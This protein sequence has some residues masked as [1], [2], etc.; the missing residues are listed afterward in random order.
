MDIGS[1]TYSRL[2]WLVCRILNHNTDKAT[3]LRPH[4]RRIVPSWEIPLQG[5]VGH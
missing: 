4:L 2:V 1:V 3:I 5:R